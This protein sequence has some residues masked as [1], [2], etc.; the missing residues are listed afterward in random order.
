MANS[1][2]NQLN[3]QLQNNIIQSNPQ[4]QA[5]LRMVKE[6]G[7]SP[8]DLFFQKT[9]EMGVDPNSILSQLKR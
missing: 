8:K 5:V 2:Y 7:M 3:Q 4:L 9:K 6:S 1:L